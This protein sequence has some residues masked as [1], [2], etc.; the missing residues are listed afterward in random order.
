MARKRE[1]DAVPR[2]RVDADAGVRR[3]MELM[4][5]GKWVSGKSHA[6]VAAEHGVEPVT[7]KAW[8]T[9]ASRVI[10]RLAEEDLPE[11]RARILAG[12]ER[13]VAMAFERQGMSLK[14]EPYDNPDVR[15]AVAAL[16]VQAKILGLITQKHEVTKPNVTAMTREQHLEALAKLREEIAAEEAK[17][18]E[19]TL[20]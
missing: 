19:P 7:V 12:L 3:C 11:I 15:G 17:L 4:T 18:S 14:G 5:S 8:A 6:E 13:A 16:E 20:Q 1:A 9:S 10:R 2:T